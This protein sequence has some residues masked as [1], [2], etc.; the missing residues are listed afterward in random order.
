MLLRTLAYL[1]GSI[2]TYRFPPAELRKLQTRRLKRILQAADA[3]PLYHGAFREAG[4]LPSAV[5]APEGLRSLPLLTKSEVVSG[6]SGLVRPGSR[7]IRAMRKGSGT[8][9][10][11]VR[12]A[13]SQETLDL[14][15]AM[16]FRRYVV[17][18]YKPWE[19]IVTLW[20]PIEYWRRRQGTDGVERPTTNMYTYPVR[21]WGRPFPTI[22]VVALAKRPAEE[23]K[24]LAERDPAFVIARPLHLR[25]VGVKMKELGVRARPTC[26]VVG[27]ELT[28]P[29]CVRDLEE[30]FGTTAVRNYGSNEFGPL[31]TECRFKRGI[32]LGEDF[33]ICE[34]LKDGEAVGPGETGEL[35]LTS[36]FND[37]MPLIRFRTGDMVT[38]ADEGK[39]GCGSWHVRLKE[40]QGRE[41]DGLVT[42]TGKRVL[43]IDV[44]DALETEF[45]L[46]DFQLVQ[47]A[48]DSLVLEASEDQLEDKEMLG[49]LGS[50]LQGM[51][52]GPV[53]LET[54]PRPERD[55]WL[56]TRPVVSE[57][58]P[59]EA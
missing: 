52:G 32:H 30:L 2:R 17:L 27:S 47:R 33:A 51:L 57:V 37:V 7:R 11:S 44:A 6:F 55:Y 34:V 12:L 35:V 40:V 39:C 43:P 36:L 3:I 22:K 5:T 38:L 19:R 13:V 8:S 26:V 45:G 4:L 53:S 29:K 1:L 18:G 50:Y 16:V 58:R 25:R 59:S 20:G 49:R 21:L 42:A 54:R 15:S 24:L 56:K 31:G 48:V 23:A 41:G 10:Q 46:R 28:T 14:F 9:G